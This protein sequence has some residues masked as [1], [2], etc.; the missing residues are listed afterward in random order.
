MKRFSLLLVF[1]LAAAVLHSAEPQVA[2]EGEKLLAAARHK[3]TID[4]DLKGAIE[5]YKKAVSSSRGNRALAA[6]ALVEMAECHQKLGDLEAAKIYA[7]IVRDYA[8]QT[9]AASIARARLAATQPPPARAMAARQVWT[10]V[11]VDFTGGVSSDGRY[12]SF[13]DWGT[14]NLHVRDLTTGRNRAITTEGTWYEVP[15][16]FAGESVLSADGRQ[17][18]YAWIMGDRVQ[19]RVSDTAA[20]ARPTRTVLAD[21]TISELQP[22]AWS[23]DARSIAVQFRRGDDAAHIAFV[24]ASDGAVRVLGSGAAPLRPFL[25]PDGRHVAFDRPTAQPGATGRDVFVVAAD[26][27]GEIPAIVHPGRD[28][29]AGWTPDGRGLIFISDRAGS[30]GFWR[31]NWSNGGPSGEPELLKSDVNAAAQPLGITGGGALYYGITLSQSEIVVAGI[32][33]ETHAVTSPPVRPIDRFVGSNTSP[34]WSPD[35]R[36]L[37]YLSRGRG[38]LAIRDAETGRTRELRPAMTR[39]TSPRWAPDGRSLA[40]IGSDANGRYGI[41]RID[42]S[43]G[44]VSILIE[45]PRRNAPYAHD[46]TPDGRTI[47]YRTLD[48]QGHAAVQHDLATGQTRELTRESLATMCLSPDGRT[49]ASVG[50]SG[51]VVLTLETGERRALAVKGLRWPMVLKAWTPDSRKVLVFQPHEAV[52]RPRAKGDLWLVSVADGSARKLALDLEVAVPPGASF[53]SKTNQLAI[54]VDETRREVWVLENFLAGNK[55]N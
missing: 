21:E 50:G 42:A 16:Q 43:T 10:G 25:S 45:I 5:A 23:A 51:L 29:V 22:F 37:S 18:A 1:V 15:I 26:G 41:Y 24:S 12:L 49:L 36:L 4:G 32:D 13:T 54:T 47:V 34:D 19:L 46:W 28:T 33:P 40:V 8:D 14:G 9:E 6:R 38:V 30:H 2:S 44:D 11:E 39:M 53:N 7:Q 27:S 3:A 31:L 17:V 35:G 20:T 52:D 55:R 48:P